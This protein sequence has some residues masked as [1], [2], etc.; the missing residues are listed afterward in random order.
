VT[1]AP[2]GLT[3]AGSNARLT[4]KGSDATDTAG[5][6]NAAGT[7][8]S[9]TGTLTPQ[10]MLFRNVAARDLHLKA[11][12]PVIDKGGAQVAGESDRDLEGRPR[13]TG[14]A[15][16]VGA[17]EFS[18]SAPAAVIKADR[19]QIRQ[20]ETVAFDATGSNDVDGPIARY[21]FDF[22]DGSPAQE[23]TTG[24][25]SHQFTKTGTFTSPKGGSKLKLF[26]VKSR[27][28]ALK[29]VR[30]RDRTRTTTTTTL[31]KVLLTGTA[32]DEAGVRL[33]ELSL[34]RVSVTHD[35]PKVGRTTRITTARKRPA[36]TAATRGVTP[37]GCTLLDS[38]AKRFVG[39][40][41]DEPVFF[42]VAITD[43]KFAYRLKK[44]TAY[45]VGSYLLSARA[46]DADA[47]AS[48]PAT[49]AFRLR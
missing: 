33:V 46:I 16:D 43:G 8:V 48:A 31:R 38:K 5:G 22:G 21:A 44:S 23:S 13:V 11:S 26:D 30:G 36:R 41:C 6:G 37:S 34:R 35:R 24:I 39:R 19:T 14:A 18:H 47:I 45:R 3:Q 17:D 7:T 32:T 40:P 1:A 4:I 10:D 12:A 20:G 9:P 42:T 28:T 29:P 2:G 25:V 15:S 27:R 49:S